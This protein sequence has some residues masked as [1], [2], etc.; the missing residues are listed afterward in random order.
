MCTSVDR[1]HID[2]LK[3]SNPKTISCVIRLTER[4]WMRQV[5]EISLRG[6]YLVG[7]V[8]LVLEEVSSLPTIVVK[9]NQYKEFH[10][11]Q[12]CS[13]HVKSIARQVL[14]LSEEYFKI[15]CGY[16]C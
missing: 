7:N 13:F 3:L 1:Q 12:H 8:N 2:R 16:F 9:Q 10:P 5:K 6:I 14:S 4:I 11:L 15:L